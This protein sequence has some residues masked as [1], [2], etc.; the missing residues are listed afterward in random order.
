MDAY[1]DLSNIDNIS[2]IMLLGKDM[3]NNAYA[4]Y[5][6]FKVSAVAIADNDQVFS[7]CNVENSSYSLTI[8]AEVSAICQ[9]VATGQKQ[10]KALFV[11]SN[12]EQ[13]VT[14]CGGCRQTILEFSDNDI[15]I[16]TINSHGEV[17]KHQLSILIP[18]AFSYEP[19]TE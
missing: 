9:M 18:H 1:M 5:S 13:F 7:G 19:S 8:C 4:P 3:I 15:P 17:R 2:Q 6:S 16:F 14:P 10:L 12:T 11:F